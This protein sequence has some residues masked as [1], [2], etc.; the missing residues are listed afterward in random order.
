MNKIIKNNLIQIISIVLMTIPCII[1]IDFDNVIL[2]NNTFFGIDTGVTSQKTIHL[3]LQS[4]FMIYACALYFPIIIRNFKNFNIFNIIQH[5]CNLIIVGIFMAMAL[6]PEG[7]FKTE[8]IPLINMSGETLILVA[9]LFSWLGNPI[10][11][12][13][14]WIF[15]LITA[16]LNIQI[17]STALGNIGGFLV[18]FIYISILLQLHIEN[19]GIDNLK[20]FASNFINTNSTNRIK[21]DMQSS[22]YL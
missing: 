13:F 3:V 16:T 17:S 12:G 19:F 20:D 18:L 2:S 6:N 4:N 7:T 8:I 22:I 15:F 21:S 5:C 9:I 10:I 1:L 14:A 11:A